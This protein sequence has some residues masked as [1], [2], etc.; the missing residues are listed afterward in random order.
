MQA[1]SG[2]PIDGLGQEGSRFAFPRRHI[3]NYVF[4]DHGVVR[5][6]R[7]IRQLHFDLHLAGAAHLVVVV[8]HLDPP[9]FH[10]HADAAS[11][12]VTHILRRGDMVAAVGYF[13]TVV[14]G[15]VQGAVPVGLSG[16]DPISALSGGNL[17]AGVI[18]KI[19]FKLG[20]DDHLIRDS[21]LFHVVYGAQT[22]IFGV[23]V[24]GGVLIFTDYTDIAAHGECGDVCKG[25]HIGGVRVGQK[26]HIAFF[27]GSV[28]VVGA[29]ETDS[30]DED[31]RIKPLHRYGD[32]TPASV[33]VGH[34]EVDHADLILLTQFF[35]FCTFVHKHIPLFGSC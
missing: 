30:I 13:V 26:H 29:V 12:V 17:I 33:N 20:T 5:H 21:G 23:L 18:E 6:F 35:D 8:F 3:F 31:V 11:Q 27:N 28:P 4:Y 34:F 25:V 1:A 14:A 19:K 2:L 15:I 9:F 24:E 10:F 7:H 32:V 22:Y 16:V